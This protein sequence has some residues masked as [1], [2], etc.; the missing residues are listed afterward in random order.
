M[1]WYSHFFS[2]LHDEQAPV[3]KLGRGTHYSILRAVLWDKVQ[4]QW[5]DFAVIWDE[6]HDKRVIWVIEQLHIQRL[7]RDVVAIG[8][9]KGGVTIITSTQPSRALVARAEQGWSPPDGD[10][11]CSNVEHIDAADLLINDDPMRVRAYVKGIVALWR[12]GT[13]PV[14]EDPH[15]LGMMTRSR[16]EVMLEHL[17]EVSPPL[18]PVNCPFDDDSP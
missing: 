8:E 17:V 14:A 2:T 15:P 10:W 5:H 11:F 3:G 12:L 7:L 9:R 18:P 1:Q 4:P 16:M 6:D 13:K